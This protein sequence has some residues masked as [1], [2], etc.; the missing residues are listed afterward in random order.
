M[1]M[2]KKEKETEV[3]IMLTVMLADGKIATEEMKL[4]MGGCGKLG[5]RTGEVMAAYV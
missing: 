4:L 5:Y 2:T 1:A 3:A